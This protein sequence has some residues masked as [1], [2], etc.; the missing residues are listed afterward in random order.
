M[1]ELQSIRFN[2]NIT[3][4]QL[5]EF[6]GS[7]PVVDVVRGS[8]MSHVYFFS[9]ES[10]EVLHEQL[11]KWY[12]DLKR[13]ESERRAQYW[14]AKYVERQEELR[15]NPQYLPAITTFTDGRRYEG[16]MYLDDNDKWHYVFPDLPT[17]ASA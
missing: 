15:R 8:W 7:W 9:D 11:H 4:E 16:Y 17:A 6:F 14:E 13:A 5:W 2:S 12:G 1:N 10:A 3:D